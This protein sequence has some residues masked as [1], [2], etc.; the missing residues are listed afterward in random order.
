MIWYNLRESLAKKL[1]EK[2]YLNRK[3]VQIKMRHDF[4]MSGFKVHWSIDLGCFRVFDLM[5]II[6]INKTVSTLGL[7]P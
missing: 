6:S 1:K 3:R 4:V 7:L 2:I 5:V